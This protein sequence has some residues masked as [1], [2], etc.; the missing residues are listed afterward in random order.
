MFASFPGMVPVVPVLSRRKKSAGYGEEGIVAAASADYLADFPADAKGRRSPLPDGSYSDQDPQA[1]WTAAPNPNA[2]ASQKKVKAKFMVFGMLA[3]LPLAGLAVLLSLVAIATNGAAPA[4]TTVGEFQYAGA[5]EV[6]A[7]DFL[8]GRPFS[9]PTTPEIAQSGRLVTDEVSRASGPDARPPSF[10]V[11]SISLIDSQAKAFAPSPNSNFV[12]N[13]EVHRFA[14]TTQDDAYF[15]LSITILDSN[16]PVLAA[17]PG[18]EPAANGSPLPQNA[19]GILWDDIVGSTTI[20]AESVDRIRRWAIAYGDD[21]R[22]TLLEMTGDSRP[23][24]VYP[25]LGDLQLIAE[26]QIVAA[27]Q[28]AGDTQAVVRVRLTYQ[29]ETNVAVLFQVELDLL[30]QNLG[31]A[32]PTIAAWGPVGTGAGIAPFDNAVPAEQLPVDEM[33]TTTTTLTPI[34]APAQ[35]DEDEA[36]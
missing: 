36:N 33:S 21:D 34:T 32:L 25:G 19:N 7:M 8:E 11:S 15:W 3:S 10:K 1:K 18:I 13:V 5:A 6:A 23:G 35:T 20:P 14:V 27:G 9:I 2:P 24:F 12:R 29:S 30:L 16:G 17:L 4:T 26:P 22:T 31:T 28:P